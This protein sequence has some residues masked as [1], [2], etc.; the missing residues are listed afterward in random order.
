MGTSLSIF[1]NVRSSFL[2]GE[3][4]VLRAI[5]SPIRTDILRSGKTLTEDEGSFY[6]PSGFSWRKSV[7]EFF[8]SYYAICYRKQIEPS[9][10]DADYKKAVKIPY[11]HFDTVTSL[12]DGIVSTVR[13]FH[14]RDIKPFDRLSSNPTVEEIDKCRKEYIKDKDFYQ[15]FSLLLQID[16]ALREYVE[17]LDELIGAYNVRFGC[18]R[19][20]LRNAKNESE[21][22]KSRKEATDKLSSL[23]QP[24]IKRLKSLGALPSSWTYDIKK[25]P[26][27]D[28]HR[29]TLKGDE[30]KAFEKYWSEDVLPL[31]SLRAKKEREAEEHAELLRKARLLKEEEEKKRAESEKAKAAE[32]KEVKKTNAKE[33]EEPVRDKPT[34]PENRPSLRKKMETMKKD[35]DG[36]L[37]AIRANIK[38]WKLRDSEPPAFEGYFRNFWMAELGVDKCTADNEGAL[39][40]TK[41]SKS[42]Y[43]AANDSAYTDGDSS[44]VRLICAASGEEPV[45]RFATDIEKDTAA[46]SAELPQDTAVV[47]KINT[48]IVYVKEGDWRRGTELDVALK[49]SCVADSVGKTGS[50]TVKLETTWYVCALNDDGVVPTAWRE[51]TAAESDTAGFGVP[52]Y[53]DPIVRLGNVNKSHVYVY[54]NGWRYGTVLDLD[55]GL[56]PCVEDE[57]NDVAQLNDAT[58]TN[59]WYICVDDENEYAEG[60]RIPYVWRKASNFERDTYSWLG[61]TNGTVRTSALSGLKYVFDNGSWRPATDY[62]S[63][64]S[65]GACVKKN[66]GLVHKSGDSDQ[67]WYR[68]TNDVPAT[69]DGFKIDYTWRI[70]SSSEADTAGL[71]E[72]YTENDVRICPESGNILKGRL[73]DVDTNYYIYNGSYWKLATKLQRNTY[74]YENRTAWGSATDGTSRKASIDDSEYYVYEAAL[75]TWRLEKNALEHDPSLGGCTVRRQNNYQVSNYG[76]STPQTNYVRGTVT[77]RSADK[78]YYLCLDSMWVVADTARWDTYGWYCNPNRNVAARS[79]KYNTSK[80]YFCDADTFRVLTASENWALKYGK[81]N[82]VRCGAKDNGKYIT[83]D[84]LDTRYVCKNGYYVW[85]DI[86]V[87]N[88]GNFYYNSRTRKSYCAVAIGTQTWL[89]ENAQENGTQMIPKDSI[90]IACSSIENDD[91][92]YYRYPRKVRTPVEQDWLNL[93]TNISYA[94]TGGPFDMTDNLV[95]KYLKTTSGWKYNSNGT[96]EYYFNGD[97]LGYSGVNSAGISFTPETAGLVGLEAYYWVKTTSGQKFANLTRVNHK[98]IIKSTTEPTHAA[99]RCIVDY[100]PEMPP[101]PPMD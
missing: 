27:S 76:Y 47:G 40:A 72:C 18:F 51:A 29:S 60:Y 61:S 11:V 50:M 22:I 4:S 89:V 39:F 49:N 58:G 2:P 81:D 43:Y 83:L 68:C 3:E 90:D 35:L 14:I 48:N 54:D 95:A 53:G 64:S 46:L 71:R 65:L 7:K 33:S 79:G 38:A 30:I 59:G 44:L 32:K 42:A 28:F 78:K 55:E 20:A 8:D 57:V 66:N 74:D 77:Y 15:Y 87:L 63:N 73:N 88:N 70:A 80:L 6:I 86:A 75:Q 56:G 41:N 16:S 5:I 84:S 67:S 69:V 24:Y 10:L 93:A 13:Q 92:Y 82:Y 25:L 96:D 34:K 19:R 21:L 94:K 37:A 36:G 62:E 85:N 9:N 101:R 99:V 1:D 12:H 97:P 98:F 52:S 23:L 26:I 45:W 17:K 100:A 31:A 91:D